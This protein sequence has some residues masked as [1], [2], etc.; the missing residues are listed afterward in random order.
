MASQWRTVR[1]VRFHRVDQEDGDPQ[2]EVQLGGGSSDEAE[3]QGED[4]MTQVQLLSETDRSSELPAGKKMKSGTMKTRF[5]F[6]S[7][8]LVVIL[9]AVG[10]T[11]AI[12]LL[13]CGKPSA[14]GATPS[15]WVTSPVSQ[16]CPD[17]R[18]EILPSLNYS[19]SK[20]GTCSGFSLKSVWDT[21]YV[22][23]SSTSAV[24]FV[25]VNCDGVLDIVLGF[26]SSVEWPNEMGYNELV[27]CLSWT[28]SR[29]KLPNYCYGGVMAID[30]RT[31]EEL[32]RKSTT[33][34]VFAIQCS[35]DINNDG[36]LDCF[37][38]GR[39]GVFFS[40]EARSGNV[41][42]MS[43]D[44]VTNYTWNFLTPQVVRDF[45]NDGIQDIVVSHGGD[46]R[47]DDYDTHRGVGLL[48]LLSGR[49]GKALSAMKMP[50]SHETYMSPILHRRNAG[51]VW[52][53][54]GS[55]GESVV[56]N[57]WAVELEEFAQLGFKYDENVGMLD[58]GTAST[59]R[60]IISGTKHMGAS[61]PP[62]LVDLNDDGI[63]DVVMPMF[64]GRVIAING[65][66]YNKLW[67]VDFGQA[68]S[69]V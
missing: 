13:V 25:D 28:M 17:S 23:L 24:R 34:E 65:K 46:R 48:L 14:S 61:N 55:G 57:L 11:I 31:G 22:N 27:H 21:H 37:A 3:D 26:T 30:G 60:R 9:M 56:G 2:V 8:F 44:K 41:L 67:S 66:D 47:Y 49:T 43:D 16:Y 15:T 58:S 51:S 6:I 54:F 35:I 50:D 45:D 19:G 10:I 64:D 52:V 53:L 59:T 40:V 5:L 38:A 20:D 39:G 32:W 68:E 69:Y 12:R 7:A 1:G 36:Y 29:Y 33:H 62:V 63:L 18:P 42:W 4:G